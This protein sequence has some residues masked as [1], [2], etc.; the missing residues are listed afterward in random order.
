MKSV[1]DDENGL[2]GCWSQIEDHE[3]RI[4]Q[5]LRD[6]AEAHAQEVTEMDVR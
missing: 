1:I 6:K 2:D 3:T 4:S 5:G